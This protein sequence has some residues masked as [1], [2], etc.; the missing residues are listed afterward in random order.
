M[1]TILVSHDLGVIGQVCDDVAV[2]YAGRV[3]ERG[4]IDDVLEHPRHP[5]TEGLA[6]AVAQ[7]G[8]GR[9]NGTRKLQTLGGQPPVL[10]DLP[11]G[12]SF[13][14]R[15]RYRIPACETFDMHLD[16]ASPHHGTACLVRQRE[17]VG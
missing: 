13:A 7:L 16:A 4:S 12:C 8:M 9:R 17:R 5:Y 10:T 1:A 14:P 3:V 15:C 6:H 11:P 2:M